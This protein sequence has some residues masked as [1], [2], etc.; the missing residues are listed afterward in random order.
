MLWAL[1][2]K[3]SILWWFK[4]A[5]HAIWAWSC[6]YGD[7]RRKQVKFWDFRTKSKILG[8]C[9]SQKMVSLWCFA[10]NSHK[11]PYGHYLKWQYL[12]PTAGDLFLTC[13]SW[14]PGFSEFFTFYF[15][16]FLFFWRAC[17]K[18]NG[19]R[20]LFEPSGGD[21]SQVAD[22]CTVRRIPLGNDR[23]FLRILTTRTFG[24]RKV[25]KIPKFRNSGIPF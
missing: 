25:L 5:N 13:F 18:K 23:G 1:A 7:S 14:F 9:A 20:R 12:F 6:V 19:F 21:K 15:F 17:R 8:S 16:G 3:P 10:K 4:R 2:E 24:H 22:F 11:T